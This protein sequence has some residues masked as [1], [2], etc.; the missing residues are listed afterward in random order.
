MSEGVR[1][2]S[3]VVANCWLA[4]NLIGWLLAVVARRAPGGWTP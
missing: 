2:F 1:V 3:L 4:G